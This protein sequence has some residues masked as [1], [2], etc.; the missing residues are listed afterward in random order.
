MSAFLGCIRVV[1]YIVIQTADPRDIF[2]I[3][4]EVVFGQLFHR[5]LLQRLEESCDALLQPSSS[6]STHCFHVSAAAEVVLVLELVLPVPQ[7]RPNFQHQ[8]SIRNGDCWIFLYP[9]DFAPKPFFALVVV[10]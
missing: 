1:T 3:F 5:C 8:R 10:V 7:W 2:D 6:S 9:S 4:F